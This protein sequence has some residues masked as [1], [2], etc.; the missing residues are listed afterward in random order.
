M[1][2][3]SH[4]DF[5]RRYDMPAGELKRRIWRWANTN[6]SGGTATL[7]GVI[8]SRYNMQT[9]LTFPSISTIM[10]DYEEAWANVNSGQYFAPSERTVRS[11]LKPLKDAGILAVVQIKGTKRNK[12][13]HRQTSWWSSNQYVMDFDKA[14]V[15]GEVIDHDFLAPLDAPTNSADETAREIAAITGISNGSLELVQL[16]NDVQVRADATDRGAHTSQ[17]STEAEG[18]GSDFAYEGAVFVGR[19]ISSDFPGSPP[20]N[21]G[22]IAREF[23]AAL[24]VYSEEDL[25]AAVTHWFEG[26]RNSHGKGMLNPAGRFMSELF[27]FL[28]LAAASPEMRYPDFREILDRGTFLSDDEYL[29]FSEFSQYWAM[30][31]LRGGE[32]SKAGKLGLAYHNRKQAKLKRQARN[33]EERLDREREVQIQQEYERWTEETPSSFERFALSAIRQA[34]IKEKILASREADTIQA[35][36]HVPPTKPTTTTKTLRP[37]DDT[38]AATLRRWQAARQSKSI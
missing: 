23:R 15:N 30:D 2:N 22:V 14:L 9:G 31:G 36:A 16:K 25:V 1:P 6:A 26:R 35:A 28:D 27:Y 4:T 20:T 13:G 5:V 24:E 8:G 32:S 38:R 34:E 33:E 19:R 12:H 10:E 17:G 7:L 11:W 29:A 18:V 21:I 37:D 3:T